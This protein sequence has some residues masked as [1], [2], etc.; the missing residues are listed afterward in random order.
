MPVQLGAVAG[1]R[2]KPNRVGMINAQTPYLPAVYAKRDVDE[3]R[4]KMYNLEN[5]QMTISERLAL[6]QMEQQAGQNK[7]ANW[8]AAAGLPLTLGMG[9]AKN[10]A[11]DEA[12]NA[13]P[14]ASE[15][16]GMTRAAIP[17]AKKGGAYDMAPEVMPDP[18]GTGAIPQ[19]GMLPKGWTGGGL[20][21]KNEWLPQGAG[22]WGS[23]AGAGVAGFGTGKLLR[24]QSDPV[25]ALAGG[26][27]GAGAGALIRKVASGSS[28]FYD[29]GRDFLTGTLGGLFS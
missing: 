13:P 21:F 10:R 20:N 26:V 3:Y 12:I 22:E 5:E 15:T 19:K 28:N 27:V 6:E 18:R 29:I 8:I 11:L 25:K 17:M 23:T 24:K 4:A 14:S 9:M 1:R 2:I 7:K 16:T